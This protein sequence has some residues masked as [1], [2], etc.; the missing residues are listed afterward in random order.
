[1]SIFS[2]QKKGFTI[3]ESLISISI[4]SVAVTGP[5]V[6]V[7]SSLKAAEVARDQTIAFYLAQDAVEYIKNVRD[8]NAGLARGSW[9][10]G[11]EDCFPSG[12]SIGCTIDTNNLA[13]TTE[14][15]G[16]GP[17]DLMTRDGIGEDFS[18]Y[19]Y[20]TG[21]NWED[22]P[23]TR[24]IKMENVAHDLGGFEDDNEEVKVT[25]TIEWTTR[26]NDRVV[27]VVENIF[28][29]RNAPDYEA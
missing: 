19:G 24:T 7:T 28:N 14:D 2:L 8:N 13:I 18:G 29:L 17:C 25:V 22:S 27:T 5:L 10:A 23:F 20:G 4:L 9:L 6:Y 11:L 15:C 3:L 16:A 12:S 21:G 1:M 26:N